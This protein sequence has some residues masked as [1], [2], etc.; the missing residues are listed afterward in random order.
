MPKGIG[1]TILKLLLAS[2]AV[3]WLMYQFDITPRSLVQNFGAN[4]ERV[5]DWARSLVSWAIPY[6]LLGAAI[7]V[8]IWLV[9]KALEWLRLRGR[10]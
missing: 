6:V 7:V 3:G 1:G 5:Y 2:L 9:I 4:V 10:G 8:P